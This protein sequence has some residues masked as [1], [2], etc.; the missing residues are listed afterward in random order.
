MAKTGHPNFDYTCQAHWRG[1]LHN[2][3]VIG[4]HSGTS[5]GQADAKT[6]MEG[7]SSPY[8]LTF[9]HFQASDVVVVSARY[10]DGQNSAPVYVA[11]YNAGNPA[12]APLTAIGDA[13]NGI[14]QP[15]YLPLEVCCGLYSEVGLSVKSKPVYN[16]KYLRGVPLAAVQPGTGTDSPLFTTD[17]IGV[18]AA[19]AM[20]D[21]SWYGGRVYISPTAR[22][23]NNWLI[24]ANPEN[25]QV[26][27]GRKRKITSAGTGVSASQLLQDAIALAGGIVLAGA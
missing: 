19:A 25:H 10:Y 9:A 27:R 18:A 17:P 26:P 5:F 15:G 7:A 11:D 16:R 3:S 20:G 13:Y 24:N 8:A 22:S 21:G 12:P 23:A 4:N 14:A 2:F 1:A 6:F